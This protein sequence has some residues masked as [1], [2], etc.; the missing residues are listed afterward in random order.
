MWKPKTERC[1]FL[2]ENL[3][4]VQAAQA[5]GAKW[6]HF[7]LE[8]LQN[9]SRLAVENKSRQVAWSFINAAEAV[10][11]GILTGRGTIFQSINLKEATEKIRYAVRVV[12]ALPRGIRP[13][14]LTQNKQEIELENGARVISLPGNPQRGMAQFNVVFDEWAH[15][16]RDREVYTAALPVISKGGGRFRGGSS[17]MGASGIFW[18]IFSQEM[19]KFPGFTRKTTPWWEVQAFCKDIRGARK[20]HKKLTA[21]ELVKRF[22]RETIKL[23]FGNMLIEDFLQEY[24]CM[25]VDEATAWI[26]WDEIKGVQ[27]GELSCLLTTSRDSQVD[28]ALSAVDELLKWLATHVIEQVLAVGVD[29]GR[30]RNTTEIFIFGLTTLDSYPLRAAITLDN[31]D[32]DSQEDVLHHILKELPVAKMFI[33][34][35][36]IGM[37]LAEKMSK[38]YPIKAEGYLFTNANKA[39]MATN[40]KVIFQKRKTSLP[41]DRAIAHQIHSIKK[42]ITDSRNVVYDSDRNEKHHADKFW[43]LALGLA[44]ATAVTGLGDEAPGSSEYV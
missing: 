42:L 43:A 35:N 20:L 38:E 37:Q 12:E 39:L 40:A 1:A 30:T 17:P 32:F 22:G 8:H 29:V 19:R 31:C 27:D 21:E 25:F 24:C 3:D 34:Q 33:D 4:L 9:D 18:E 2:V 36:G 26:T 5:E 6:E 44:A 16:A 41:V 14:L 13:S 10:A 7:Q 28:E 23:I 11:D 15:I